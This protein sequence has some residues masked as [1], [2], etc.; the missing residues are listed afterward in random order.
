MK[1]ILLFI[2]IFSVSLLFTACT[3]SPDVAL[4]NKSADF[5]YQKIMTNVS[6]SNLNGADDA[7]SSLYSEHSSSP[8]LKESMLL[9]SKAHAYFDE[10]VLAKYYL[11]EY[12]KRFGSASEREYVEYLKVKIAFLGYRH[13][14]RN[15]KFLTDTISSVK[16][17]KLSYPHSYYLPYVQEMLVRLELGREIM[18]DEIANLYDRVEKPDAALYYRHKDRLAGINM[19]D[20]I[21]PERSWLRNIFE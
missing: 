7:Y 13:P 19:S 17:F 12:L 1:K 5:W 20:V 3:D 4:A 21:V 9:L 14:F 18:K 8:Y 11:D 10:L 2:P 6:N 16:A 15:Q